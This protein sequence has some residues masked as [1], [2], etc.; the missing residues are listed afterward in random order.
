MK[1]PNT[2][3]TYT[4]ETLFDQKLQNLDTE[5]RAFLQSQRETY[6]SVANDSIEHDNLGHDEA[7]DLTIKRA[8]KYFQ[9]VVPM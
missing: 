1:S 6:L 7:L 9:N 2:T 3:N 8:R 5:L 4:F